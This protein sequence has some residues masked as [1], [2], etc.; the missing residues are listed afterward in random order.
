MVNSVQKMDLKNDIF[1]PEKPGNDL[2]FGKLK[3]LD[4]L[5]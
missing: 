2:E 1:G 5:T 3:S 4:T